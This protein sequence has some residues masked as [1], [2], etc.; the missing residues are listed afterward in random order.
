MLRHIFTPRK[1]AI[2]FLSA[3]VYWQASNVAE[4]EFGESAGFA[5]TFSIAV[6]N[7]PLVPKEDSM[8]HLYTRR[9][10]DSLE[11]RGI[12]FEEAAKGEAYNA[13]QLAQI[14]LDMRQ[15]NV[16]QSARSIYTKARR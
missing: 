3:A 5:D 16:L 8:L 7:T 14:C 4:N 11:R 9:T 6:A 10:C 12:S 13:A 1:L 15:R 2:G